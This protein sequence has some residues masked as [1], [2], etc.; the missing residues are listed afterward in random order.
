M[1]FFL[2][3]DPVRFRSNTSSAKQENSA[4]GK[5]SH[6]RVGVEAATKR[7]LGS[8][9]IGGTDSRIWVWKPAGCP[10][11]VLEHIGLALPPNPKGSVI[12]SLRLEYP[13]GMS[14]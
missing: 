9:G 5:P 6:P 12:D 7:G 1:A 11:F 4:D 3:G 2:D 14:V 8:I 13:M 10:V